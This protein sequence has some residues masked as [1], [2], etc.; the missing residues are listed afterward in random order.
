MAEGEGERSRIDPRCGTTKH[1]QISIVC[2]A[3]SPII[4]LSFFWRG[5]RGCDYFNIFLVNRL[6]R[7]ITFFFLGGERRMGKIFFLAHSM[8]H[9]TPDFTHI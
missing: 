3:S 5:E 2:H 9:H 4:S 7:E 6:K 8:V 1:H